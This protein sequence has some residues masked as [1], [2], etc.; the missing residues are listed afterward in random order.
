MQNKDIKIEKQYVNI[1]ENIA[2]I[3]K[4]LQGR[5]VENN[6]DQLKIK[7]F[8]INIKDEIKLY[9]EPIILTRQIY[10]VKDKVTHTPERTYQCSC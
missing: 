6:E 10:N 7:D 2:V 1:K 5:D 8:E 4:Q 9:E 3:E